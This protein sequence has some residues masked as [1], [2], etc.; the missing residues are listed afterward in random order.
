MA[1]RVSP[2]EG[3]VTPTPGVVAEAPRE[4][5]CPN[6][7]MGPIAAYC[8][9]C[10][11]RQPSHADYSA[12]AVALEVG[13][14]FLSVD[15]R[16]WRS[17]VA[18]LSKPGLLTKEYFSGRRGRYMRPFS[19]FILLNVAFF[20]VQPYT[21]LLRYSYQEYGT[22]GQRARAEAKRA[23][24]SL[25]SA[26][27][28]QRFDDTI[29][30]QKK[31]LLLVAIPA[32]ALSL[33]ALYVRSGRVYVEHLVFAVHSYAFMVFYLTAMGTV[34]FSLINLSYRHLPWTRPFI[35]PLTGE[36][37]A[38]LVLGAGM[39]WYLTV[40]LRRFYGS[41]PIPALAR[42]AVLFAVQAGLIVF[43]RVLLFHTTL[44]AL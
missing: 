24:L 15:G 7:G 40:A 1:S 2:E 6:C 12:R 3:S 8:A 37:G 25:N 10:G 16:F 27:F 43:F 18:L 5:P 22:D 11:E 17:I 31:S 14:E 42:A 19:L 23:E 20:F 41:A 30:D 29:Q 32:F 35:L 39:L 13:S 44:A 28:E 21:G 36:R 34:W 38:I 33:M 26:H 4:A 9:A